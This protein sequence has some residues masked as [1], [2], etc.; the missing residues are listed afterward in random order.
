M[1]L[2]RFSSGPTG[3][4]APALT[5][6]DS[7]VQR[8]TRS[9]SSSIWFKAADGIHVALARRGVE[10]VSVGYLAKQGQAEWSQLGLRVRWLTSSPG[11]QNIVSPCKISANDDCNLAG[12]NTWHVD[13]PQMSPCVLHKRPVVLPSGFGRRREHPRFH[14][15]R[16]KRNGTP[17]RSMN[18][19]LIKVTQ[20]KAS[21]L[22][23]Q[24]QG[25]CNIPLHENRLGTF[26]NKPVS[27]N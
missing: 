10:A 3:S 23:I 9:L 15:A 20:G 21:R 13:T 8:R 7:V 5:P 19:C 17:P 26:V 25:I 14:G 1:V 4:S 18:A 27:A 2:A 16:R 11:L 6:N 24:F 22:K 12:L